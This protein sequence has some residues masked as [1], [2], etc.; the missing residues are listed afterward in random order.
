[1]AVAGIRLTDWRLAFVFSCLGNYRNVS[2]FI[3][4][5]KGGKRSAR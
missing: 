3:P 4:R 5:H 1:M 2:S